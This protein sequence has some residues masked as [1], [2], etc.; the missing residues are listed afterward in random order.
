MENAWKSLLLSGDGKC[1]HSFGIT[2]K[3][4]LLTLVLLPFPICHLLHPSWLPRV[5]GETISLKQGTCSRAVS[6]QDYPVL[7]DLHH[8]SIK[9]WPL[10]FAN[11]HTIHSHPT[12][13]MCCRHSFLSLVCL[14]RTPKS[15]TRGEQLPFQCHPSSLATAGPTPEKRRSGV[16]A[17]VLQLCLLG[18]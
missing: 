14:W 1:L 6:R 12:Q 7:S 13:E 18:Q 16:E 17:M 10:H 9:K 15:I 11:T 2:G 5:W 8:L 4:I 3:A